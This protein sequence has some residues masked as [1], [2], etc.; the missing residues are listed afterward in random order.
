MDENLRNLDSLLYE[1]FLKANQD[2]LALTEKRVVSYWDCY[3]RSFRQE[4]YVGF[5]VLGFFK[6]LL[7]KP[8]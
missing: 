4:D 2:F 1:Q 8:R 3:Y 6:N 7:V 5:R